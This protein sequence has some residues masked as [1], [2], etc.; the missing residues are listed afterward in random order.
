MVEL[1]LEAHEDYRW[2]KLLDEAKRVPLQPYEIVELLEARARNA[3]RCGEYAQAEQL[4]VEASDLA[5]RSATAV[6]GRVE[7]SLRALQVVQG[8]SDQAS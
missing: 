7:K 5:R 6:A 2:A 1:S 8:A 4:L 3:E